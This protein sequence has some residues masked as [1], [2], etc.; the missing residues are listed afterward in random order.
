MNHAKI[1]RCIATNDRGI[2]IGKYHH[3]CKHS[4]ETVDKIRDMHEVEGMG[5]LRIA[6]ALNLSKSTVAVICR[7]ER[8]A[9]TYGNWKTIEVAPAAEPA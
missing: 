7:Y 2:A 5:Y 1:I 4:D 8:R 9:Q 6:N 3:N